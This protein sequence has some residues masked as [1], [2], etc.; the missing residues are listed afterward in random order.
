[1]R[2]IWPLTV[3]RGGPSLLY[4][5][6]MTAGLLDGDGQLV[7]LDVGPGVRC[8]VTNQSAGRVHPC[9]R[10]HAASRFEVKV[11]R[12]SVLCLLPGPMIP[13]VGSR[14]HQQTSIE[15][16][17][18]GRIVWGDIL[19][20]GRTLYARAPERFVFDKLVQELQ[21]RRD[22]RLI[23]HERFAWAGPW[24]ESQTRWHFGDA[25][26]AASL[27]VSGPVAPEDLPALPD[28]QIA[29]QETAH[30]DTCIRLLGRDAEQVI[31][32]A[33]RAALT[34]SARLSGEEQGTWLLHSTGLST[35]HWFSTPPAENSALSSP[36]MKPDEFAPES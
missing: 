36:E 17:P 22:G 4:L 21:I 20:P 26:A 30:G 28:G 5:M 19:L 16:E 13:F 12:D 2:V 31:A 7:H 11:A 33:A 18:G 8:F 25:E 6:N 15:L 35:V 23:F 29:V 32:A 10:Y 3:E 34:A 1:M 24:D 14:Y 27:F 9:P